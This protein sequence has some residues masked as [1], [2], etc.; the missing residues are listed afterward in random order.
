MSVAASTIHM[1]TGADDLALA[2]RSKLNRMAQRAMHRVQ[3]L[4]VIERLDKKSRDT[5]LHH[6]CLSASVLMTGDEDQMSLGRLRTEMHKQFHAGHSFHPDI[7]NRERHRI[8]RHVGEKSFWFA[9]GADAK[10]L[11]FEQSA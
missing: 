10:T 1:R 7:Q 8:C 3:E 6:R 11:G 4:F 9:K 5:G 2:I